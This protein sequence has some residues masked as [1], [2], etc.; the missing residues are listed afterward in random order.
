MWHI[1]GCGVAYWVLR[2]LIAG[3]AWLIW[4]GGGLAHCGVW[5]G[6]L[7]G[8]AWLIVGRGVAHCGVWRDSLEGPRFESPSGDSS[9][10]DSDE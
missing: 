8:V 10:S 3:Q 2:W 6:S 9:L 1:R 4:G 7:W 5:R